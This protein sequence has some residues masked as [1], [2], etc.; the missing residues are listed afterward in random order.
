VRILKAIYDF[1]FNIS[2]GLAVYCL[3]CVAYV[4]IVGIWNIG[5]HITNW[6]NLGDKL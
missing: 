1:G 3:L 5:V 2:G 4:T 6:I